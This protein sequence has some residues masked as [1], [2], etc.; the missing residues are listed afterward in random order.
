MEYTIYD[1]EGD[2]GD[3]FSGKGNLPPG[4][5]NCTLMSASEVEIKGKHSIVLTFANPDGFVFK[6]WLRFNPDG[7]PEPIETKSG[8]STF[9]HGR[10]MRG[11]LLPSESHW[12]L[13]RMERKALGPIKGGIEMFEEAF[14]REVTLELISKAVGDKNY[15]NIKS[16]IPGHTGDDSFDKEEIPF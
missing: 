2:T 8:P 16:I 7:S 10:M 1:P 11:L 4:I 6:E 13:T 14:G 9:L 3:D 5:H 15:L 12:V